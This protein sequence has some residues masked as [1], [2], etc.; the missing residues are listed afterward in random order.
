MTYDAAHIYLSG[1][2]HKCLRHFRFKFSVFLAIL[3]FRI[4]MLL[5][6]LKPGC[7]YG[8]AWLAL[9]GFHPDKFRSVIFVLFDGCIQFRPFVCSEWIVKQGGLH[10][11]IRIKR[12]VLLAHLSEHLF[13]QP[14]ELVL[15][16]GDFAFQPLY[17]SCLLRY[18]LLIGSHIFS[19]LF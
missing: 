1:H 18:Y 13:P 5:S 12:K 19:I 14:V 7:V 3:Y 16:A 6:N 11:G 15:K 10:K 17:F 2:Q 9:E 8:F 4:Y